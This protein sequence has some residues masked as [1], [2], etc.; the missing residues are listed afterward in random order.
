LIA[1][2][3]SSAVAEAAAMVKRQSTP[4]KALKRCGAA[5]PSVSAPTRIA[6]SM[7]RSSLAQL[8]AIF[9]PIG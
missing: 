9:M 5:E 8:A 3:A 2:A 1:T 7:P 4:P 6:T